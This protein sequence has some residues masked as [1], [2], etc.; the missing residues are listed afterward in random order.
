MRLAGAGRSS[1][2]MPVIL[3]ETPR[4]LIDSTLVMAR[5]SRL[6]AATVAATKFP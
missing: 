3:V 4:S 2:I 1:F 6:S 5:S